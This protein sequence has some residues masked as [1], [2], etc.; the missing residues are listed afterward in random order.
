MSIP[1]IENGA[2]LINVV[3]DSDS[4]S[5]TIKAYPG[6]DYIT[7]F[8]N[9]FLSLFRDFGHDDDEEEVEEYKKYGYRTP[10]VNLL[11]TTQ[12]TQITDLVS[13]EFHHKILPNGPNGIRLAAF[14]VNAK[15]SNLTMNKDELIFYKGIGHALLCW[16][17][18]TLPQF[19]NIRYVVLEASGGNTWQE[20]NML[21]NHYNRLGFTQC[22]N[23]D[24]E[25]QEHIKENLS[26]C[27]IATKKILIRKCD[28]IAR[29]FITPLYFPN[30]I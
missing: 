27:M 10:L 17:L 19:E 20:N 3:V 5:V 13:D 23:D 1:L 28:T 21:V 25:Y 24:P 4:D 6:K 14:Y 11:F 2:N 22:I 26:V 30:V 18:K 12:S 8:G 9:K 7:H 29:K 16:C 15:Q